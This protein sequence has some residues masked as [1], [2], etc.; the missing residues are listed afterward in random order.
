MII[1]IPVCAETEI[2]SVLDSI[3]Q[4]HKTEIKTEVI[5]LFNKNASMSAAEIGQHI[6]SWE[7]CNSWIEHHKQ[8]AITYLPVYLDELPDPKGGVG[9]ARKMAMDEAARRLD[10]DGIIVCLDADCTVAPNYPEAVFQHFQEFKSHDAASIFY[11]HKVDHL[12]LAHRNAI[13]VYELHLRYLINAQRWCGHPY[14][15]ATI[16]SAMAVRRKSYLDQGGM[17]TRRAGEDFYFLQ[18][19]IEIG[20]HGEIRNT[21]VY[22]SARISSRVPFGT[23]RAMQQ[24]LLEEENWLTTDFNIFRQIKPLF[25][26]LDK[27][28]EISSRGPREFNYQTFQVELGISPDVVSY[29]EEIDFLTECHSIVNQTASSASFRRRFFRYFNSFRMIKYMHYMGDHYFPDVPV[30]EAASRLA[31]EMKL[32]VTSSANEDALLQ[33]FRQ[34][35]RG[36]R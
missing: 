17:N 20:A 24:I 15:Y 19:F 3:Y 11:E 22:P 10:A 28:R 9:W 29:L 14:A 2:L 25:Q 23:G 21:V 26:S 18:K 31:R 33:I 35:D 5:L 34:Y 12:N 7:Q 6:Q 30:I 32:P 4:S 16:G 36:K 8:E 1:C 13:I 27:L